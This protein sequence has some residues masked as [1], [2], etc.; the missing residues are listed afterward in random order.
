MLRCWL[1]RSFRSSFVQTLQ[2]LERLPLS[3]VSIQPSRLIIYIL[4]DDFDCIDSSITLW[5][6]LFLYLK[7]I[8]ILSLR[9]HKCDRS[10]PVAFNTWSESSSDCGGQLH[11]RTSPGFNAIGRLNKLLDILWS[12]QVNKS[13][14]FRWIISAVFMEHLLRTLPLLID[15][16]MVQ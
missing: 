5:P 13:T 2:L 4:A 9:F 3:L 7:T 12:F 8:V 14:I 10:F 6:Q 1:S 16:L 11:Q 15:N